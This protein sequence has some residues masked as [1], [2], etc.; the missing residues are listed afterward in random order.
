MTRKQLA[1]EQESSKSLLSILCDATFWL[2]R[3]DDTI[4]RSTQQLDAILGCRA[5][6]CCLSKYMLEPQALRL[7]N[8]LRQEQQNVMLL[9]TLV[10]RDRRLVTNVD[11]FIVPGRP[12]VGGTSQSLGSQVSSGILIGLRLAQTSVDSSE[13]SL[14]PEPKVEVSEDEA[15]GGAPSE[16]EMP[17][18]SASSAAAV[19]NSVALQAWNRDGGHCVFDLLSESSSAVSEVIEPKSG[20]QGDSQ[21]V[22]ERR[23]FSVPSESSFATS[24]NGKRR[25]IEEVTGEHAHRKA[26]QCAKFARHAESETS[27]ELSRRAQNVNS[28]ERLESHRTAVEDASWPDTDFPIPLSGSPQITV[29]WNR[30]ASS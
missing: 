22:R 28:A 20:E 12:E 2:S 29:P 7:Q 16:P 18:A 23:I 4:L 21:Q 8:V 30:E 27:P 26:Q 1:A 25:S 9:H 14:A 5:E 10:F 15:L 3:D 6:G 24:E 19:L 11:L 13:I 17:M